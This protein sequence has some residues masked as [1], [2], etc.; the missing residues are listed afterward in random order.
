L[1]SPNFLCNSK[2]TKQSCR[3]KGIESELRERPEIKFRLCLLNTRMKVPKR[4]PRRCEIDGE[5]LLLLNNIEGL[6]GD[7]ET[8]WRVPG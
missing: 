3:D 6:V 8:P 1:K 2:T 5:R 7:G 4:V